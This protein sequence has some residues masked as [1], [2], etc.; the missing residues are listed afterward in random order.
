MIVETL[1]YEDRKRIQAIEHNISSHVSIYN[2]TNTILPSTT[3]I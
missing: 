2:Y 1:F 3:T